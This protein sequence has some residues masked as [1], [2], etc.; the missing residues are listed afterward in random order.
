[1]PRNVNPE[2]LSRAFLHLVRGFRLLERSAKC[3]EGVTLAQCTLLETLHEEGPQRL[4][5]MAAFLGVKISTATRLVDAA[6]RQGLVDRQ[7]DASDARGVRVALTAEGERLA[8]KI[9][10]AGAG[11]CALILEALPASE[12]GQAVATVERLAGIINNLPASVCCG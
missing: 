6:E 12:R 7:R 2:A 11:F 8:E 4:G 5:A 10:A 3:C 9:G 1:M